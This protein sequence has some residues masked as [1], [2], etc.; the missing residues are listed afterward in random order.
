MVDKDVTIS[1]WVLQVDLLRGRVLR[2]EQTNAQLQREIGQLGADNQPL[3]DQ[4]AHLKRDSSNSSKPPSSDIVKP[5][6]KGIHRGRCKR[7]IG[8][9]KGHP[10]HERI[11]F[12]PDD[13]GPIIPYELSPKQ[14][15]GLIP[16]EEW[17]RRD[18]SHAQVGTGA[19]CGLAQG[20]KGTQEAIQVKPCL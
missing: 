10:R 11:P 7:K 4:V 13:I 2:L 14:A 17:V 1:Q 18:G 12:A 15:Q 9:Q 16:L 8:G 6:N 3:K 5:K 19:R 20:E